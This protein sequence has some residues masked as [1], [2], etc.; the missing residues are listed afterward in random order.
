MI[1]PSTGNP[2]DGRTVLDGHR[3]NEDEAP[4]GKA[5]FGEL[6]VIASQSADRAVAGLTIEDAT[7]IFDGDKT[8]PPRHI[9]AP[10]PLW[11]KKNLTLG[12]RNAGDADLQQ[13]PVKI[14]V[15][16]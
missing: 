15:A 8:I 16:T 5:R 1:N 11:M 9:K 4:A 10:S 7:L 14:F 2:F 12:R 6:L 3:R 13:Q